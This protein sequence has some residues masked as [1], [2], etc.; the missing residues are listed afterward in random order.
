MKKINT[1]FFMIT[2]TNIVFTIHCPPQSVEIMNCTE[3]QWTCYERSKQNKLY[4]VDDELSFGKK[5]Y[6]TKK[7]YESKDLWG[8]TCKAKKAEVHSN[9]F[10]YGLEYQYKIIKN[11][12]KKK[13]ELESANSSLSCT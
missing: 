7:K 13:F 5:S 11:K 9:D 2:I 6:G 8:V 3:H 12:K 4:P 10:N 1:L